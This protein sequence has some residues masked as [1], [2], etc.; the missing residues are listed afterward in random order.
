VK[1]V[2][3]LPFQGGSPHAQQ[4]ARRTINNNSCLV[5]VAAA[6]G[7][8]KRFFTHTT[9]LVAEAPDSLTYAEV[10]ILGRYG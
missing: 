5:A 6:A 3:T 9:R 2:L 8:R 7:G 1:A 4:V 10:R